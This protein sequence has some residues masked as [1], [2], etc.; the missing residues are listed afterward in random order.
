MSVIANPYRGRGIEDLIDLADLI[1][2]DPT[3]AVELFKRCPVAETTPLVDLTGPG[4]GRLVVKNEAGRMGLGSFKALGA[5]YAIARMAAGRA[6]AG[7]S[8]E[9]LATALTD[10]VLV[11]ASAGNHG[12]SVAAG[13][14]LFGAR[15]VVYLSETVSDVFADRLRDK[16]ATVVRSGSTYEESMSAS[17]A[18]AEKNAWTLLS[19]SSWPGY[20]QIPALVMEGYTIIA[21]EVLGEMTEMPT[22]VYLQAG[23]GGFAA[24]MASVFRAVWG[25]KPMIVVVEPETARCL[26]DS[27]TAGEAVVSPGPSTVMGRLDCKT[28]SMVALAS[29]S[30]DADYFLT[31]SDE[32]ARASTD[33]LAEHGLPTTPS[34][35]AGVAG[36]FDTAAEL[37]FGGSSMGLAFITEGPVGE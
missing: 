22:H 35:A 29:L 15:A 30:R 31:I 18:A 27:V 17:V 34:G 11:C 3:E 5:T 26:A 8:S 37:G 36:A 13:A 19:D 24:A 16:G 9:E 12:L 7:A 25:D 32:I 10:E 23:V 4:G 21:A 20:Q 33:H 1:D 6:G 14:R 28:P 2:P